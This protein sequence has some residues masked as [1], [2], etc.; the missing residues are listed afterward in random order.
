[1]LC[2]PER[3]RDP[4]RPHG[5]EGTMLERIQRKLREEGGFTLIELV[6]VIVILAILLGLALP[7]Y[8]GTRKKAY[9]AEAAEKL[10]EWATAQWMHYVEKQE[11]ADTVAVSLPADTDNWVF[12]GGDCGGATEQCVA[13][14]VGQAPNVGGATITYTIFNDGRREINSSGF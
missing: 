6:M 7:Q 13:S 9:Y 14:A 5:K 10:Q 12:G 4:K 11:F 8:L 1:M 2:Y 3:N